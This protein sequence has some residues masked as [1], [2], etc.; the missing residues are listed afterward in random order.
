MDAL[1]EECSRKSE[2]CW[3]KV[4]SEW[5]DEEGT[6]E[7]PATWEG[8]LLV[9]EDVELSTIAKQLRKVLSNVYT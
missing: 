2:Q 6:E 7:Y 1:E 3:I 9:L 8:I 5:L 4:M